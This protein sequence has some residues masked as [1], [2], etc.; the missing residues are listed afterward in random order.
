MSAHKV[1]TAQQ[2]A[3]KGV[4]AT[5]RLLEVGQSGLHVLHTACPQGSDG[6]RRLCRQTKQNNVINTMKHQVLRQKSSSLVPGSRI[7]TNGLLDSIVSD[8]D[9]RVTSSFCCQM[10]EPLCSKC[11]GAHI[12]WGTVG[13]VHLLYG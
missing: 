3:V 6:A 9:P 11:N 10:H 7:S 1:S 5:N 13:V 12:G 4:A 2:C 8:Q